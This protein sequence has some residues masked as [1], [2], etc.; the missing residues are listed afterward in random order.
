MSAATW[1]ISPRVTSYW[2]SKTTVSGPSLKAAFHLWSC[3]SYFNPSPVECSSIL[4]AEPIQWR[5]Y[6]PRVSY[7]LCR[8]LATLKVSQISFLVESHSTVYFYQNIISWLVLPH[9]IRNPHGPNILQTDYLLYFDKSRWGTH[10][11]DVAAV[12]SNSHT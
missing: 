8:T 3:S 10:R 6:L 5:S 12:I 11:I 7:G 4:R 2:A 1:L 9:W